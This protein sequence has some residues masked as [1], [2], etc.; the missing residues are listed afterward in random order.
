[1]TTI[2]PRDR[3]AVLQSLRA[4][5]VPRIGQHLIQVGRAHELEALLKD[6]ERVADGG[7]AFRIVVGEYGAGKTFFLNLVRAIALEK[8]LVTVHADLNPDR[9]L[10]ASGGQARSLYAELVKN[11]ATRTK[12]EGG[13]LA[14]VVEKFIGQ[15]KTEAKATGRTSDEV[16]RAQLSQLTEMVNGYDFADVIAA[17]CRGFEEGNEK[18]KSDAVRWLRG[19]F[20]TRTDARQALGVRTIVDDASMYDQLKLL[21]RFV[22]LAGYSGLMVCLDEMVNLY[23]LANVQARNANYEQILRILNDSLQGT[24]EGL[25][26]VLGGTPEFLL[27]TRR[28]LYS[29]AALQSRLAENAFATNG[30]VDYSG[31][32][33]RLAALTPE[34]F[35]VLLD[36]L[37][38]VYA[39]GD[40]SK[41][42]V[43]EEAIPA[44]MAHCATRLGEAYFR[45]PRTTITAF[46]NFLAVLE[47]NP[48]ADWRALIGSMDIERDT[49]GAADIVND[50]A[51]D[52]DDELA[53]FRLN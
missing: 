16:I 31:P 1:M 11:M 33:I 5:V 35:Y 7:S 8:K 34:D 26:F 15:A 50:A 43:P 3:D 44:F 46:I 32:V 14:G 12:P 47:Q 10:H 49:G 51:P 21:G 40:A 48:S 22:R 20:T 42:L 37:R 2:R 36:K 6:I 24:A 9:R 4:G 19:E 18:L 28:G 38:I 30:L 17:Y 29:Y 25:G 45:T 41:A 53:S 13:A 27:D 23:K 52:S 39:F